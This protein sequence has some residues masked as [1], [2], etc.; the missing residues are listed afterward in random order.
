MGSRKKKREEVSIQELE[1][2]DDMTLVSD[3]MD[4]LEEVLRT[5]HTI[6]AGMGL[7]ISSKKSKILAVC[8]TNLTSM[9]PRAVQLCSGEEPVAVGRL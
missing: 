3:A 1:Y 7:S 4:V 8:S 9:Q 2:A 5:V 6:C